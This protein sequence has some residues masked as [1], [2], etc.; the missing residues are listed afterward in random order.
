MSSWD[1][2][3]NLPIEPLLAGCK[4]PL[5]VGMGGGFD[6]FCGLPIYLELRKRGWNA[7]LANFSFTEIARL[8]DGQRLT[9]T[10]VGIHAGVK[11]FAIYFPELY[12]AQWFAEKRNHT[13]T[14]WCFE[15]TGAGPLLDNYRVLVES[16]SIDG[17]VLI[18]GGVDSLMRGDEAQTGTMIE[19]AISLFAVNALSQIP[20]RVIACLGFGSEQ[21][22]SYTQVLENIA[23][24]TKAG[25]FLGACSLTPEM[26][27]YR[28]YE[29]AVL[30]TQNKRYQDASVI[31]SSIISAAHGEFG[32]YHLTE[33][34]RGSRLWI[35]PLMLLYWF[36]DLP[37]VARHNLFLPQLHETQT[38]MEAVFAARS[39]LMD[40]PQRKTPSLHL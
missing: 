13:V 28:D 17:I 16:L 21:D 5:I 39:A 3:L 34:T 35:S 12:L 36:F 15:K 19:D 14:V 22:V 10:L 29:E 2:N 27:A 25:G 4:N 32:N 38:F 20:I 9:P 26:E 24:L 1:I 23:T 33:K 30:Y 11:D 6:V 18:D 37:T 8:K 31:N 40:V 7:H